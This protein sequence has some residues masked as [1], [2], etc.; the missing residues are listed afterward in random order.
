MMIS[1]EVVIPEGVKRLEKSAFSDREKLEKIV[2]PDSLEY[3]GK[4]CFLNC[5]KLKAIYMGENV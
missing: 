5:P 4:D 1:G 3:I 2:L